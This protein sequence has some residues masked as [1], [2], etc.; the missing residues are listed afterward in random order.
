MIATRKLLIFPRIMPLFAQ[1]FF[2]VVTRCF[3]YFLNFEVNVI[4]RNMF[5]RNLLNRHCTR[6]DV[7]VDLSIDNYAK[8][9]RPRAF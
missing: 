3:V 9:G 2:H 1:D 5:N 4:C 7:M 6:S 8:Y